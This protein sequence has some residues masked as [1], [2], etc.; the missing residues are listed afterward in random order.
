MYLRDKLPKKP[1]ERECRVVNFSKNRES[2][3]HW[4]AYCK[5]GKNT[6]Y[7]DSYGQA[8][9]QEITDYLKT[10]AEKQKPVIA[11]NTNTVQK[12]NTRICGHLCSYVLKS[13]SVRQ[14]YRDILDFLTKRGSGIT[15]TNSM[16][17]ELHK[18]EKYKFLKRFVFVRKVDDLWGANL[19]D[20][21]KMAKNSC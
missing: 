8:I 12:F 1:W 9:L 3:T 13:F 21:Q 19:V 5:D 4:V 7:F 10:E 2:E 20:M 18:P 6:S 14:S 17:N 11:R 15:W 16:A